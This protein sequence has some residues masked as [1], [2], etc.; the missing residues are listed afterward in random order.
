MSK[1]MHG[2]VIGGK[3]WQ[4]E[5]GRLYKF[6]PDALTENVYYV[7]LHDSDGTVACPIDSMFLYVKERVR[8]VD[9]CSCI[10]C[11][12]PIQVFLYEDTLIDVYY[13][14]QKLLPI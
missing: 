4:F 6:S 8:S 7:D 10:G 3:G 1:Q 2:I 12:T 13:A 11:Q 9:A 14:Y 5:S